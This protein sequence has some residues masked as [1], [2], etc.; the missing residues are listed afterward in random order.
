MTD[1][2]KKILFND[3]EKLTLIYYNAIT[4]WEIIWSTSRTRY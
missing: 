2:Q 3:K 4:L 1:C